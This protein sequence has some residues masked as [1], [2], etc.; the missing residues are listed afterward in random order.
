M[1]GVAKAKGEIFSGLPENGI[2]IMN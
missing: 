1:A 2:A